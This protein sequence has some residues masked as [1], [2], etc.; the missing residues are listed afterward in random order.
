MNN[1]ST[2]FDQKE[3]VIEKDNY[4]INSAVIDI[5]NI[6]SQGK[7]FNDRTNINLKHKDI[8]GSLYDFIDEKLG[9]YMS[10]MVTSGKFGRLFRNWIQ[11]HAFD[12]DIVFE[13]GD[14]ESLE[15]FRNDFEGLDFTIIGDTVPENHN[16]IKEHLNSLGGNYKGTFV[17]YDHIKNDPYIYSL[18]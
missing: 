7:E 14:N 12:Y 16:F 8:V 18:Y 17:I 10:I 6:S 15:M 13:I 3:S 9:S 4:L 1:L 11:T 5:M 2:P